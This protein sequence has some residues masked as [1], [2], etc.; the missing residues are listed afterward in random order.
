MRDILVTYGLFVGLK[1]FKE[2]VAAVV[3]IATK[4]GGMPVFI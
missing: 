4:L 1:L 3:H 2:S